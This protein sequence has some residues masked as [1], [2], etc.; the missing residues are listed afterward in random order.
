MEP[1]LI[2][3]LNLDYPI[4]LK[5]IP[6]G[7][8]CTLKKAGS[9]G[10]V[11]SEVSEPIHEHISRS[12]QCVEN[13]YI[14]NFKQDVEGHLTILKDDY[15]EVRKR[16]I[17][18]DIRTDY[19]CAILEQI[20]HHSGKRL[21]FWDSETQYT[22]ANQHVLAVTLAE[23][24]NI[25][26][27]VD[28][29][30]IDTVRYKLDDNVLRSGTVEPANP[31]VF[32]NGQVMNAIRFDDSMPLVYRGLVQF[33]YWCE[34]IN[35]IVLVDGVL[36]YGENTPTTTLTICPACGTPLN[37]DHDTAYC[38][39]PT[40]GDMA[41]NFCLSVA[42]QTGLV[43]GDLRD[44]VEKGE[45]FKLTRNQAN[46]I[47]PIKTFV[48][49]V[50]VDHLKEYVRESDH[51]ALPFGISVQAETFNKL[52]KTH[53]KQIAPYRPEVVKVTMVG[54]FAYIALTATRIRLEEKGYAMV[55]SHDK[56]DILI[57]AYTAE[58]P[59]P[60]KLML[61]TNSDLRDIY[62]LMKYF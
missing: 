12:G 1:D 35:D 43:M 8:Q 15:I 46:S 45:M 17:N 30:I 48:E 26:L 41:A 33:N 42:N 14:K 21:T 58:N 31:V 34:P 22:I 61:R 36:V 53:L 3:I 54:N 11:F 40:C 5:V 39:N 55:D 9:D 56:A 25:G 23:L 47:N 49:T 29:L 37:T 19:M 6:V 50:G 20:R 4:N 18:E 16:L 32:P 60:S 59:D 24:A 27:L 7:I 2:G 44:Q 62:N 57:G 52:W 10:T 13:T 38:M 28:S 51:E